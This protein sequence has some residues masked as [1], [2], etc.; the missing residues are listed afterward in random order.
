[1]S[2]RDS[3]LTARRL[4][5]EEGILAGGSAGTAVFAAIQIAKRLGAGKTVVTLI[6]DGG[7]ALPL[8]VLRRQ[9]DD[10]VRLPGAHAR[11]RR[12]VDEVLVAKHREEPERAGRSSPSS[13]T[14]SS[15]SAIE[16]MQRYSI[17][18]LPVVRH[19][20]AESLADFVGSLQERSLLDRVF[21]N[22][23]TLNADV[24]SAMQPPLAAVDADDSVDE[25]FARFS[26]GSPAVVVARAG[27]PA[28][29]LSRSDLLEYLAHH[30]DQAVR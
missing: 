5:R 21:K 27:R 2:D 8:E 7:R 23:D 4:A 25:V 24:A 12:R 13:R 6:P 28:G 17:S 19:S 30:R 26:D 10:R 15:A 22:P 29:M 1:M 9:L 11:R 18:Q 16:L 3:F 20:P 14:R